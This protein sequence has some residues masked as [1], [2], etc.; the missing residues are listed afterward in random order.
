MTAKTTIRSSTTAA[1]TADKIHQL[2]KSQDWDT[3]RSVLKHTKSSSHATDNQTLL[4]AIKY[5][6]P[7]HIVRKLV[8]IRP[9]LMEQKD[10]KYS[11]TP[12]HLLCRRPVTQESQKIILLLAEE[13]PQA[14]VIMDSSGMT[15]LHLIC[16]NPCNSSRVVSSIEALCQAAPV[17]LMMTNDD[18]ETPMECFLM[19]QIGR[20]MKE[21]EYQNK[22]VTAFQRAS[23][24]YLSSTK[25]T[26][27]GE[28]Y[29]MKCR[30]QDLFV[31]S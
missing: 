11:Q 4:L 29:R 10:R 6:A 25:K 5:D 20:T 12:L 23:V 27:K 3:L 31:R 1:I 26:T 9:D 8:D 17:A 30:Q 2:I 14:A 22:A 13:Y 16:I 18:G 15:P 7:H 28:M 24:K 19:S 21:E